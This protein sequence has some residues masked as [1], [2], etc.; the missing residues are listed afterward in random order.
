MNVFGNKFQL[1][2]FGTSHAPEIGI[3]ITGVPSEIP[4]SV[5][6]LISD[7][8]RRKSGATGTTTRIEDDIPEIKEGISSNKTTGEKITIVFK[9]NNINP[10]EY[11][12]VMD[13]PRPGHADFVSKIKY[14]FTQTGGGIFSGRMTLPLVAAGV[15]AKKLI[16]PIFVEA[17]LVEVGE[18]PAEKWDKIE[19]LIALT[20][21][22]GDSLGGIIACQCNNVSVGLGEPFFDSVESIISHAIFS[23][24][25]IRGIEFG[26]GFKAAQMKGSEHNDC[27]K[28]AH[29]ETTTNG[30]GGI[31][32]GI[33]NGNQIYFRVAVKPTSSIKKPQESFNLKTGKVE[34]FSIPG[35][36]DTCFALRVPVIVEAMTAIALAQIA[37]Y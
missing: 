2:I 24:P 35:R 11:L 26:D 31:N 17:K 9:N 37:D 10:E 28:N 32:G 8:L 14:G 22:E 3:T 6:D 18:I 7:I 21:Q 30:C 33:T 34:E 13:I 19:Q 16:S 5:E 4:L 23:I 25:G 36:H 1:E 12:Q 15:I 20:V 29:G 27:I